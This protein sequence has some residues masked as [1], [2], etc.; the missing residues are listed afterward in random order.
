M[1]YFDKNFKQN[2]A[3]AYCLLIKQMLT[4]FSIIFVSMF[5]NSRT[6][7]CCSF[8][9]FYHCVFVIE[10]LLKSNC[11]ICGHALTKNITILLTKVFK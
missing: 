11:T 7:S 6:T 5:F 2:S 8:L 9:Y 10:R 1:S 4:A 3:Y